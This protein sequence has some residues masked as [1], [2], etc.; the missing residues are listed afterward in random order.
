MKT[1]FSKTHLICFLLVL[2]LGAAHAADF[3]VTTPGFLFNINGNGNGSNP[4][5]TLVRGQTYT[6]AINNASFH[7]FKILNSAGVV[8]NNITAGTITYTVPLTVTNYAYECSIHHFT[9]TIL[10]I[11][12]PSPVPPVIFK[13]TVGTNLNLKFTG[14]NT[15][16]YFPEFNTNLA[17]TNWFALTVVATNAAPNGTNDVICGKPPG[18]NV[19]IRVRAQ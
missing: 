16:S 6:F 2:A 19:F 12:P 7:P 13:F 17:S 8:N 18:N 4:T 1:I 10:T 11:A 9:G 5:I 14:S 3:N 15:F